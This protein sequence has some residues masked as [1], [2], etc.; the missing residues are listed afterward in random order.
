MIGWGGRVEWPR[1][2]AGTCRRS[3]LDFTAASLLFFECEKC[4]PRKKLAS[5]AQQQ[6]GLRPL[7]VFLPRLLSGLAALWNGG[8][9]GT[10]EGRKCGRG[11]EG[12]KDRW[13]GGWVGG[14]RREERKPSGDVIPV[15]T[16]SFPPSFHGGDST[17]RAA[18]SSVMQ[19]HQPTPTPP[20]P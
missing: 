20:P 11:E 16:A 5:A 13:T 9:D 1:P 7:P 18:G 14:G 19:L 3:H 10:K 4:S 6:Q 17:G 12:R 15:S 8:K 2:G